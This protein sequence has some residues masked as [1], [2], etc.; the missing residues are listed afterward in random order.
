MANAI[1]S[2]LGILLNYSQAFTVPEKMSAVDPKLGILLN[3]S[4][5]QQYWGY[6]IDDNGMISAKEASEIP[7][8]DLAQM[9]ALSFDDKADP[10]YNG[11]INLIAGLPIARM[12]TLFAESAEG[13][14]AKIPDHYFFD[15]DRAKASNSPELLQ[16]L[17]QHNK[18]EIADRFLLSAQVAFS[19]RPE[20]FAHLLSIYPDYVGS[21]MA[22]K[23]DSPTHLP[24][25]R[26]QDGL[27]DTNE[28][29]TINI[30]RFAGLNETE[31]NVAIF[32]N[33]IK[34]PTQTIATYYLLQKANPLL[35][36]MV[37][38]YAMTHDNTSVTPDG[39]AKQFVNTLVRLD[40]EGVYQSYRAIA[41]VD[42]KYAII[43]QNALSAI[44]EPDAYEAYASVNLA[45]L[46]QA[47]ASL[48]SL[49]EKTEK[50]EE[51]FKIEGITQVA[52]DDFAKEVEESGKPVLIVFGAS[53]CHFCHDSIPLIQSIAKQYEGDL[54]VVTVDAEQESALANKFGATGF[55]TFVILQNGN[56]LDTIHGLDS[57]KLQRSLEKRVPKGKDL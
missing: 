25:D 34:D 43:L 17:L 40:P 36:A 49:Q 31:A 26:N 5:L 24:I 30:E 33:G 57:E 41:L 38:F 9:L 4:D 42:R 48:D 23:Y 37:M 28:V 47:I 3:T 13:K 56:I 18:P 21:R 10:Q 14:V 19:N 46:N 32:W 53:W 8:K 6:D 39:K 45:H 22:L 16:H 11:H 54:K 1:D 20:I 55:P 27:L 35:R 15:Y 44:L 12:A 2:G 51:I 52:G 7:N 29:A 50:K